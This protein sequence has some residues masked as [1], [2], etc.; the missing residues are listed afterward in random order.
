MLL[1]YSFNMEEDAVLIENAVKH[2]LAGGLRTADIMQAGKGRVFFFAVSAQFDFSNLPLTPVF[3]TTV[4]RIVLN[5][6][7]ERSTGASHVAL[8]PLIEPIQPEWPGILT[9]DG[10][11]MPLEPLPGDPAKA[12]FGGATVAGIYRLTAAI[13]GAAIVPGKDDVGPIV[14]AVNTPPEESE[15]EA[16]PPTAISD[17][18]RGSRL[19]FLPAG[20]GL[21]AAGQETGGAGWS[22][23]FAVIAAAALI[24]A[25]IL[26]WDIDRPTAPTNPRSQPGTG[27]G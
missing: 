25:V 16:I 8:A 15:L 11:V 27:E 2:V 21:A 14:A 1:R 22:F 3:L 19:A 9:P 24:A 17:L 18:L 6:I 5:H 23:P 10:R 13:P 26:A 20:S 7:V 12:S 4:H